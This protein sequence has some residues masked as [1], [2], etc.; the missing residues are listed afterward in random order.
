[1]APF[2]LPPRRSTQGNPSGARSPEEASA[3]LATA[4]ALKEKRRLHRY[5]NVPPLADKRPH[6]VA[7]AL[8]AT[9]GQL[10]GS[11]DLFGLVPFAALTSPSAGAKKL[12]V[13]RHTR[14]VGGLA[15]AGHD[16]DDDLCDPVM[17]SVAGDDAGVSNLSFEDIGPEETAW[18]VN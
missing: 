14:V 16:Y 18:G 13:V 6:L 17:D 7:D 8:P 1:M 3:A 11:Q 15:R 2:K 10:K 5:E 12:D 4:T 9:S